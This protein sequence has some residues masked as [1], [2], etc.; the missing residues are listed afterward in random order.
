MLVGFILP[1]VM[2]LKDY[3][4]YKTFTLYTSYTGLFQVGFLDGIIIKYG[5]YDYNR[6]D[7]NKFSSYFRV[8]LIIQ[9]I[10]CAILIIL[11]T[12]FSSLEYKKIFYFWAVYLIIMNTIAF[13]QTLSK[14]TM[15]FGELALRNILQAL[16]IVILVVII[17]IIFKANNVEIKYQDYI[18]ALLII[19]S[20]LS[21][22]YVFTYKDVVFY[23]SSNIFGNYTEYFNLIKKGIPVMVA[24]LCST[25]IL[26][27]DRQFVNVL[28][29]TKIYAVYAFAYTMLSLI[30]TMISAVSTVIYP[31]L[32][33]IEAGALTRKYTDLISILL[34]ISSAGLLVYQPLNW[35]INWYIPDYTGSLVIFRIVLPGVIISSVI[36]AI[37]QNYYVALNKGEIFF[38]ITLITLLLAFLLNVF[39]YILFK[40]TIAISVASIFVTIIWY[41]ISERFF[42]VKYNIKWKKNFIFMII[43]LTS[44]YIT[45]SINS[46]ILGFLSYLI[47]YSSVT[48]LFYK[49][50]IQKV[51]KRSNS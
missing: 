3:G 47:V 48:L 42:I 33:R 8:Y 49:Q 25:L 2:G 15:R 31:N 7:K 46:L 51:I 32:K 41:I 50:Q 9:I 24:Y 14:I 23:K 17:Y 39:S 35:F 34:F 36:T 37:M 40:S 38:K 30:T 1:K 5:G 29:S 43:I 45:S 16:M 13:F 12:I 18:I 10:F 6:I 4:L 19:Y 22:W 44:F 20:L 27:L 28:F 11:T 21:I 26:I